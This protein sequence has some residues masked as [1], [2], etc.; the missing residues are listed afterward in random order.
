[1]TFDTRSRQLHLIS[2]HQ[3]HLSDSLK[4]L[5]WR[6]LRGL[7]SFLFGKEIIYFPH[8]TFR[9]SYEKLCFICERLTEEWLMK[10][11]KKMVQVKQR[12]AS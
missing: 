10:M 9:F 6:H 2:S 8:V 3:Q 5:P 11:D 7:C 1:M 12:L 4:S